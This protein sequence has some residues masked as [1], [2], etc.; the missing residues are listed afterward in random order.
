MREVILSVVILSL[1]FAASL[2]GDRR[3]QMICD[4]LLLK[5]EIC[6]TKETKRGEE[7]KCDWEKKRRFLEF[8]CNEELLNRTDADLIGMLSFLSGEEAERF[9][10]AKKQF[11]SD[12]RQ[13]QSGAFISLRKIF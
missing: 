1:L 10:N 9:E 7:L 2:L 8:F 11:L 3:V 12:V 5:A 4:E 6:E 13:I